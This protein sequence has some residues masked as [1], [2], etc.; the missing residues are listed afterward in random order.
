MELKSFNPSTSIKVSAS[1][2]TGAEW[3]LSFNIQDPENVVLDSLKAG[4][5]D[6]WD[7]ADEL[8]KTTCLEAFWGVAGE[9]AYWELNLSPARQLWNLY[10]FNDYRSP[11]PPTRSSDF[12]LKN[13]HVTA[14]SLTCVLKPKSSLKN[15]EASLTAIVR[16]ADRTEYFATQHAGAKPDFHL[17][18]SFIIRS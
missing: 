16:M 10:R 12:E 11:Q 3:Q 15:I 13:I 17:R 18:E 6:T 4:K 8:W 14:S 9:K 7:R 5:W 1:F 2:S